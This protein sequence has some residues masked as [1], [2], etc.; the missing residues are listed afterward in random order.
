VLLH[1]NY[2]ELFLLVISGMGIL[3]YLVCIAISNPY[4]KKW[5]ISRMILWI[6]GV[7]LAVSAVVGPIAA[8]AHHDF[9]FHMIGHL[10]LGMLAPLLLVLSAPMTLLL[11]TLSTS[12]ARRLT[13]ILRSKPVQF[14]TNP[15]T[16]SVLNIGGL[17]LL[18]TTNLYKMMHHY[19]TLH[20]LIHIH[21]FLVGYLFT[22]SM[23]Y[24]DP[25]PHRKSYF[26]R[27]IV[28]VLALTGHGIL[29]KYIYAFPPTGV[30]Q[31]QAEQGGILMYYGG[32]A[33]DLIL[34]IIFC[35]QWYRACRPKNV[36]L[37]S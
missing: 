3:V 16:A 32:D 37:S 18:Y 28:F 5:P 17:W 29:S 15:L 9:V 20:V 12:H 7:L 23:I 34:I 35:S 26:Y 33:V 11:R 22:V 10:L 31:T 13:T 36:V 8:R 6:L 24:I 21:V 27:A 19:L 30:A 1:F 25:M 2:G 14:V 4:Y